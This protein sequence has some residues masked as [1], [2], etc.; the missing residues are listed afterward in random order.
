MIQVCVQEML[1]E[2]VSRHLGAGP[3]ERSA[4]RQGRRN[5]TH[6]SPVVSPSQGGLG[7]SAFLPWVPLRFTHGY[8]NV[9][10]RAG[11]LAMPNANEFVE[12]ISS[13]SAGRSPFSLCHFA[14]CQIH[15]L[16]LSRREA[17]FRRCSRM[18]AGSSSRT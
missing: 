15:L 1:E 4:A 7:Y 2:E 5:S 3:Y 8:S 11:K 10:L 18:K 13:A 17:C 14:K 9:A 16:A 6:D 12:C